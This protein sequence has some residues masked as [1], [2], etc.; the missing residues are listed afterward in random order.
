MGFNGMQYFMLRS[1]CPVRR[2]LNFITDGN[3]SFRILF[4]VQENLGHRTKWEVWIKDFRN[5]FQPWYVIAQIENVE[6][7]YPVFPRPPPS[8]FCCYNLNIP[9]LLISFS[10]LF[11]EMLF[12]LLLIS[13]FIK[14][15]TTFSY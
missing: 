11:L 13:Y 12:Q 2:F 10:M 4:L 5:S 7:V 9:L 1:L 14:R 6:H 15:H 8:V 3:I